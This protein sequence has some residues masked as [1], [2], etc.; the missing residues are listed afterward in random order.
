MFAKR[1]LSTVA[2]KPKK[3]DDDFLLGFFMGFVTGTMLSY[4]PP[5]IS[6]NEEYKYEMPV[7]TK[8]V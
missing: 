7:R 3:N 1:F 2:H 4:R 5:P 8:T 6:C